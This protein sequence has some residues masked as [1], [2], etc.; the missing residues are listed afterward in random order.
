M[1]L[2]KAN[3]NVFDNLMT[4]EKSKIVFNLLFQIKNDPSAFIVTND[5]SYIFTQDSKRTPN[6]LFINQELDDSTKEEIIAIISGMVRI[7]P[8][9]RVNGQKKYI[10]PI[11]EEVSARLGVKFKE[12]INM[13]VHFCKKATKIPAKGHMIP[14]KELHRERLKELISSMSKDTDGLLLGADDS[15]KYISSLIHSHSFFL[16]EDEK[17][18]SMAKIANKNEGLARLNTIFTALEERNNG[19]TTML[20]GELC[21]QL[22][23]EGLTPIIYADA[24]VKSKIQAYE[25]IGFEKAGD[26]TQFAF[27]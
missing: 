26:V 27:N 25:R 16:W 5:T 15:E 22:L 12:E 17:I 4:D 24:S 7:N 1:R 8:L 20:V 21:E 2:V 6:W 9:L 11:L 19:Y 18:V 23:S 13:S 3:D 14:P 10:L